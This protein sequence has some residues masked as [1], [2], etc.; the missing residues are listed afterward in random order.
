MVANLTKFRLVKDRCYTTSMVNK[1][2][3]VASSKEVYN[4]ED[5]PKPSKDCVP[6]WFRD[7]PTEKPEF[8]RQFRRA[9]TVK[10]CVPYLDALTFGYMV[11]A[12]QDIGIKDDGKNLE[13][14]WGFE[15]EEPVVTVDTPH[16]AEGMPVPFGYKP[17]VFRINVYPR[18]LTPSGYSVLI[19]HPFNRYDLP[20]L[21]LSGVIDSDKLD[22][23]LT[24]SMYIRSDFSGIIEKGTPLAQVV[25]FK[26]EDWVNSVVPPYSEE[27]SQ[28]Q[29]FAVLSKLNRSYQKQFWTKKSYR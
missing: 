23:P 28:K 16:R 19:T 13:F 20:F 15:R 4:T 29:K 22:S 2:T 7:I 18:I 3:F 24:V 5:P 10:K 26:R 9:S 14:A 21:S 6:K 11:C 1:I 27:K 17:V 8:G 25:P 12:P